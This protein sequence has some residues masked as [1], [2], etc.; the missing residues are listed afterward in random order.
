DSKAIES[1]KKEMQSLQIVQTPKQQQQEVGM[2]EPKTPLSPVRI[3]KG[4]ATKQP[5]AQLQQSRQEQDKSDSPKEMLEEKSQFVTSVK[6]PNTASNTRHSLHICLFVYLFICQKV[7]FCIALAVASEWST[8]EL[9]SYLSDGAG[10]TNHYQLKSVLSSLAQ[11]ANKDN[12]KKQGIR[13][14][15]NVLKQSSEDVAISMAC[16]RAMSALCR[17]ALCVDYPADQSGVHSLTAAIK[18]ALQNPI[19]CYVAFMCVCNLTHHNPIHR[20]L[21]LDDSRGQEIVAC[22][23]EGMHKFRYF[24]DVQKNY[25]CERLQIA[26]CLALQNLAAD[27][28]GQKLIGE[29]GVEAV[30]GGL[31]AHAENAEVV[32][33]ALGTLINLCAWAPNG[34]AFIDEGGIECLHSLLDHDHASDKSKLEMIKI[35]LNIANSP[36]HI[37]VIKVINT[38][39]I[40]LGKSSQKLDLLHSLTQAN[41]LEITGKQLDYLLDHELVSNSNKSVSSSSSQPRED[42]T[43]Q[44]GE[45]YKEFATMLS[46]AVQAGDDRLKQDIASHLLPCKMVAPCL[47]YPSPPLLYHSM[48]VFFHLCDKSELQTKLIQVGIIQCLFQYEW[49]KVPGLDDM[50]LRLGCGTMIKLLADYSRHTQLWNIKLGESYIQNFIAWIAQ[51]KPQLNNLGQAIHVL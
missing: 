2:S 26:A 7:Q 4:A 18:N 37:Q 20:A 39:A 48:A 42:N 36:V 28:N 29:D 41:W 13:T 33:S 5:Q 17:S 8:D 27:T 9:L 6:S 25:H 44:I 31:I 30:V 50:A 21:I 47:H 15:L 12:M 22:I 19:F 40:R 1:P 51:N 35:L 14:V 16:C 49:Y 34:R 3:D 11:Q 24:E 45:C 38:L 10:A 43:T 32:D 46:I 23:L